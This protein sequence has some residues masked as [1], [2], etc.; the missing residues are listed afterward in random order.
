M[1]N[2]QNIQNIQIAIT[3]LLAYVAYQNYRIN[4]ATLRIQKDKF[5]LELF[6]RRHVILKALQKLLTDFN[7]NGMVARPV[8]NEFSIETADAEF[9]FGEDIKVYVD[10]VIKKSLRM[11]H[12]HER[13]GAG[14]Q[15]TEKQIKNIADEI[16]N[17]EMW[18]GE[19]YNESKKIF[20]KYLHFSIS[21][22]F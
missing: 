12:L 21:K 18:F 5:R 15:T 10:D 8:L 6:N 16:Y 11:I 20:R 4:R 17:L 3:I 22:D 19:Q 2:I 13:L 14:R 9:L 1:E 7:K